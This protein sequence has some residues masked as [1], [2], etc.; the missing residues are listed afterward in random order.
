MRKTVKIDGRDV[1]LKVN[2]RV[3]LDYAEYFG[4]ELEPDFHEMVKGFSGVEDGRIPWSSI[5]IAERMTY[6]MARKANPEIT[7][8][9]DE[10]LDQI[11]CFSVDLIPEIV[12]LWMESAKQTV[13]PKNV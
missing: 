8:K 9:F 2:A 7:V 5:L 10:W 13:T 1:E 3:P 4:R 11:D 6:I 12:T